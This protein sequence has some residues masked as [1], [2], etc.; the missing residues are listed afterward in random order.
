MDKKLSATPAPSL[1]VRILFH[2]FEAMKCGGILLDA[3]K[4]VLH[5]SPRAERVFGE[6]VSIKNGR[7]C[8]H[9]R[10]CDA[11][12]QTMLDQHLKYGGTH[13]QWRRRG[14]GLIRPDKRPLIAYVVPVDPDARAEIDGAAL[15]L[16]LVDP[17]DCVEA[18][19]A[20]LQQ[21]FEMTKAEARIANRLLCG[22]S[23]Q[24]IANDTG[25]SV[26]TVR[27]QMKA[28]F[29]KTGTHRQAE[30]VALLTRL[31]VVSESE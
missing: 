5:R 7:L 3:D 15:V 25:V 27:A 11:L 21:V 12:F 13:K 14:L 20:I 2:I 24:E 31:A 29:A 8:A 10:T 28:L 17:E 30:L 4:R 23:L 18:S 19:D 1:L 22:S 26:S 16:I 9:N 6:C